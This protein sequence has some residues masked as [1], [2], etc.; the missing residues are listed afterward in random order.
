MSFRRSSPWQT[1]RIFL[2]PVSLVGLRKM[3]CI[4]VPEFFALAQHSRRHILGN[5]LDLLDHQ[6]PP[7]ILPSASGN[8]RSGGHALTVPD[9]GKQWFS[10]IS[11]FPDLGSG[12]GGSY[13][14]TIGDAPPAWLAGHFRQSRTSQDRLGNQDGGG[15][16]LGRTALCDHFP[17][18]GKNTGNSR[19]FGQDALP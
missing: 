7:V 14:R 3:R 11:D 6:N 17:I 5:P 19:D 12:A 8:P 9:H 2:A 16:S 4:L 15:C 10:W 1:Q 13:V 18:T